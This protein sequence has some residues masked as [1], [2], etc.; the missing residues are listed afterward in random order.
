MASPIQPA[1]LRFFS[2]LAGAGSLSAAARELGV[3][4]PA[5]SKHLALKGAHLIQRHAGEVLRAARPAA[6]IKGSIIVAPAFNGRDEVK[7]IVVLAEA[8]NAAGT[9]RKVGRLHH[10][11]HGARAAHGLL[12]GGVDGVGLRKGVEFGLE[13]RHKVLQFGE[14][15][16]E[17]RRRRDVAAERTGQGVAGC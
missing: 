15:R 3:T 7:D 12:I 11:S 2:V 16:L 13:F 5:V 14:R 10:L 9:V 6:M 4:T 1:D 8:G 17:V